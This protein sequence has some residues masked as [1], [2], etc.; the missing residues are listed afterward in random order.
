MTFKRPGE[1][2]QKTGFR[3]EKFWASILGVTPTRGSGSQWTA[4]MDVSDGSILWSLKHSS[5][6]RL[7]FG[8]LTMKDLM[9]ECEE[10]INGNGGIGGS[11][12]PGVATSE[13]EEQFVTFR[14]ADFAR[15]AQ[16][17]DFQYL[18]ASKGEQK[19][20]RSKIPALLRDDED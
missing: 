5:V 2:P 18:V 10:A 1:S 17:G 9:R 12:I 7:R 11:A 15:L 20:S 14:A 8:K 3:F 16:S 13:Q 6:D 19:R 4:K